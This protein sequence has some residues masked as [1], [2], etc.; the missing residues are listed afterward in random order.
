MKKAFILLAAPF[1]ITLSKAQLPVADRNTNFE[2][3]ISNNPAANEQDTLPDLVSLVKDA[4]N[5][6]QL[7]GETAFNAFRTPGSRWREGETYIFVI[8]PEGNMLVHA[9]SGLEGKNQIDLK[10]ING[11]PIIRGL[12]EAATKI[13]GKPEGW[14]HYQWP[15]PGGLLPRWKS[16]FVVMVKA[17]SGKKYLIG[18]GMYNDRMKRNS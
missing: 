5:L 1:I 15:V 7:K 13:P 10:D 6:V 3:N 11:K 17:P 18:S 12:L 14:Y 9:D 2:S 16:S 8:D 4:S